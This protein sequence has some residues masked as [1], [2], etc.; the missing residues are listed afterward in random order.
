MEDAAS[1]E[2]LEG[3]ARTSRRVLDTGAD[4]ARVGAA[5][6]PSQRA[7]NWMRSRPSRSAAEEG[8]RM[9]G[10]TRHASQWR[11]VRVQ[12]LSMYSP[13]C[14]FRSARSDVC[15]RRRNGRWLRSSPVE[16]TSLELALVYEE[17]GD[18]VV[19]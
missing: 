12:P 4:V 9:S 3:P 6:S 16:R 14:G 7:Q 10:V 8:S 19:G 18:D 1:S 17:L 5:G 13:S 15:E 11:S 2:P